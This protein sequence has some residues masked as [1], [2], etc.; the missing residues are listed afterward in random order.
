MSHLI[1][2]IY[3]RGIKALLYENPIISNLK[4]SSHEV[5]ANI[6]MGIHNLNLIN[7]ILILQH[8]HLKQIFNK[9]I[10]P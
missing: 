1:R 7:Q 5:Q 9:I 10:E 4:I 8:F 2:S 3:L 6:I